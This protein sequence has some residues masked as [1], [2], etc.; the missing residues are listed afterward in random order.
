LTARK[1]N[2]RLTYGGDDQRQHRDEPDVYIGDIDPAA[3]SNDPDNTQRREQRNGKEVAQITPATLLGKRT[4][5]HPSAPLPAN[6]DAAGILE[7]TVIGAY[8]GEAGA[9]SSGIL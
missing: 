3:R 2:L 1:H 6:A 8:A 7:Q 9:E 4:F 5:L